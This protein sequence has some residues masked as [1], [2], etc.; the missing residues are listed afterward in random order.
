ME[1]RLTRR[2]LVHLTSLAVALCATLPARAEP[3]L[4]DSGL[5]ARSG[6]LVFATLCAACSREPTTPPADHARPAAT[7]DEAEHHDEA[8]TIEIDE[9]MLRDLRITT[10]RVESRTA[11]E[12]LS[13]LAGTP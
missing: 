3:L 8:D 7:P 10:Q 1:P 5:R 2:S 13:L 12:R 9:G 6:T 4:D 11:T